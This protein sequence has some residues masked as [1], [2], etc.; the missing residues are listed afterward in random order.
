MLYVCVVTF[1]G[2]CKWD[3]CGSKSPPC[4][5]PWYPINSSPSDVFQPESHPNFDI[6]LWDSQWLTPGWNFFDAWSQNLS[7]SPHSDLRRVS[8]LWNSG[9]SES[10]G[11][12]QGTDYTDV[13]PEKVQVFLHG[14]WVRMNHGFRWCFTTVIFCISEQLWKDATNIFRVWTGF[15]EATNVKASNL[16]EAACRVVVWL[17]LQGQSLLLE[18]QMKAVV[19]RALS[20]LVLLMDNAFWWSGWDFVKSESVATKRCK[21]RYK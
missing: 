3:G 20:I 10:G 9:C 4:W 13:M 19:G 16:S 7:N 15:F 8:I 2:L 6:C 1:F 18:K 12:S 5:N 17:P 14:E 11:A 21:F